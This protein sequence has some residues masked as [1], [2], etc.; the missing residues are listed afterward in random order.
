MAWGGTGLAE[1][2]NAI[3]G[4]GQVGMSSALGADVL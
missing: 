1:Q 4:Q 3:W 2:G